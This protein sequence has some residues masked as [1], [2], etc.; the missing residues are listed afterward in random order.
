MS[1]DFVVQYY[2]ERINQLEARVREE[3]LA[4][5]RLI[6]QKQQLMRSLEATMHALMLALRATKQLQTIIDSGLVNWPTYEDSAAIINDVVIATQQVNDTAL[7][8]M[9]QQ[10]QEMF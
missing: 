4:T 5:E 9:L 3:I 1:N 2:I 10:Q 8:T 6:V 7:A